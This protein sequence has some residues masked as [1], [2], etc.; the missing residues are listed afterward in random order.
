MTDLYEAGW[1]GEKSQDEL[2]PEQGGLLIEELKRFEP[3]LDV[4]PNWPAALRLPPRSATYDVAGTQVK[5]MRIEGLEQNVSWWIN[6][7]EDLELEA[8]M[9]DDV[10]IQHAHCIT[11]VPGE[12]IERSLYERRYKRLDPKTGQ[13]EDIDSVNRAQMIEDFA[14]EPDDE[15]A[16]EV[17]FSGISAEVA[18]TQI[19]RRLEDVTGIDL[20]TFTGERFDKVMALLA[21]INDSSQK[22]R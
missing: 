15:E 13:L 11:V 22:L 10:K 7:Y 9:M 1:G 17:L 3:Y 14:S 12:R 19:A 16:L 2:T 8:V 21:T 18:Q 20:S 4:N 5:L 6:W